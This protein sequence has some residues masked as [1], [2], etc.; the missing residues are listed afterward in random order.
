[1]NVSKW[2]GPIGRG[3]VV[4]AF[5]ASMMLTAFP[6]QA[7]NSFRIFA[8]DLNDPTNPLD[9]EFYAAPLKRDLGLDSTVQIYLYRDFL[10]GAV[11]TPVNNP[12]NISD[13]AIK[14]SLDRVVQRWND[15]GAEFEFAG[16]VVWSDFAPYNPLKPFG[17][18]TV[19]LDR[20]NLVTFQDPNVIIPG[21]TAEGGLILGLTT[22]FYLTQ[23]VDLTDLN[24]LPDFVV[25][26]NLSEVGIDLNLDNSADLAL[27]LRKYKAGTILDSDIVMNQSLA[28]YIL[29][30]EDPDDLTPTERANVIGGFDIEGIVL[31]ELGHSIGLSHVPLSE[32]TMTGRG[33]NDLTD[34]YNFRYLAFDDKLSINMLYAPFLSNLGRAAITGRIFNG[35]AFDNVADEFPIPTELELVPVFIG[36]PYETLLP[37]P[38]DVQGLDQTTSFTRNIRRFAT[39]YASPTFRAPTGLLSPTSVDNRYFIPGLP[40]S[41]EPLKV[42]EGVWLPPNDYALYIEPLNEGD[43]GASGDA[44][45]QAFGG[46]Y[47]SYVVPEF[48]GGQPTTFALPGRGRGTDSLINGDFAVQNRFLRFLYNKLGQFSLAINEQRPWPLVDDQAEVPVQSFGTMRI[49]RNGVIKD[50]PN[51]SAQDILPVNPQSPTTENEVK[52]I[53]QG[54]YIF[55]GDVLSTQ[56]MELGKFRDGSTT[57]SD[58]R[59]SVWVKNVSPTNQTLDVGYRYLVKNTLN[60]NIATAFYMSDGSRFNRETKLSGGDVPSRMVWAYDDVSIDSTRIRGVAQL[61]ADGQKPDTVYLADYNRIRSYIQ[62][63]GRQYFDYVPRGNSLT[64]P[65]YALVFNPRSLAPGE[66][67]TFSTVI[68]YELGNEFADGLIPFSG[69]WIYGPGTAGYDNPEWYLP[70]A[71]TSNTTVFGIDFLTNT[72][73]IGTTPLDPGTSDTDG[74]TTGTPGTSPLVDTDNDGIPDIYDN[75]PL[76]ANPGQEDTDGDGVGDVCDTDNFYTDVSP[77]APARPTD[78]PILPNQTFQSFGV[79]FG[80]LNNDGWPD[81]VV[82]NGAVSGGS[83]DASVNRVYINVPGDPD[84]VTGRVWRKFV[85]KTFGEDGIPGTGDDRHPSDFDLSI[86]VKLADFDL[87]GDLDM[88]VSNI[89]TLDFPLLMGWQNRFYRNEMTAD[90]LGFFVDATLEWDP[91]VLNIGAYS[92]FDVSYVGGFPTPFDRSQ[93][94]DVGDLDCDGDIDVVVANQDTFAIDTDTSLVLGLGMRTQGFGD[95]F[96]NGLLIQSD[97]INSSVVLAMSERVLINHLVEPANTSYGDDLVSR[98]TIGAQRFVGPVLFLDETLGMDSIFGGASEKRDRL[99]ALRPE[100]S[101]YTPTTSQDA[102]DFSDTVAVQISTWGYS[103]APSIFVFNKRA[104]RTA[105]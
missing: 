84:P 30:P 103:N 34:P 40:Y 67:T 54:S 97:T 51:F 42:E 64:D 98:T 94:S 32:P 56:T 104:G 19:E 38:D 41:S 57:G 11:L 6:L 29:P 100:Y 48:Y 16:N 83:P 96:Q 24:N 65:A 80:D 13:N 76:V 39:V 70:V 14:N 53:A 75:C 52:D 25:N 43:R 7:A 58:F 59:V 60:T 45:V 82:A 88:Y 15:A 26:Y 89:G 63:G 4:A 1:M 99:P 50:I 72:G 90:G 33:Q 23:D 92:P 3:V 66:E 91:G 86:D 49:V 2:L 93:H 87:D 12:L 61:D 21:P 81:L 78:Q 79:T 20:I 47:D 5:A 8:P 62:G 37:G 17:P 22:M 35:A 46:F 95:G 105:S 44:A 77:G 55:D 31:H 101:E 36:R 74:G 28:A 9:D 69:D 85:D 73:I 10:I 18:D 102:M 71:V 68:S 27:P